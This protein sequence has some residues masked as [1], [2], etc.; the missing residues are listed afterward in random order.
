MTQTQSGRAFEYALAR[1]F[2]D[3]FGVEPKGKAATNARGH[4]E[5]SNDILRMD[6]AARIVQEFLVREDSRIKSLSGIEMKGDSQGAQGDVRDVVLRVGSEEIGLSAKRSNDALKHSRLSDKI[7]FGQQWGNKPVS[8]KYWQRVR[9][10]FARLREAKEARTLFR[11][12][13]DKA[14]GIYIPVMRAFADEFKRLCDE[15]GK[16]F[17]SRVFEYI[18]G[19]HDFYKIILNGKTV[20]IQP[21]N[22]RGTLHWGSTWRVPSRVIE[23]HLPSGKSN[24]VEVTLN[25]GWQL[26]F[27][28]HNASSM[29][30]PS[31]KFDVRFIGVAL[32]AAGHQ[33]PLDL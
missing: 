3:K 11:D 29:A 19:R 22:L 25:D 33:V 17:T 30:E 12:I 9:P 10:I 18:V 15:F 27:R 16:E 8:D 4:Y 13:P 1:A 23:V 26:S 32:Y 31:L 21:F 28:I 2:G 24:R 20:R 5:S 6:R 7:D 14:D